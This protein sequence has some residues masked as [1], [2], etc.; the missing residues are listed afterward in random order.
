MKTAY[1][2][3]GQGSQSVGM[4]ADLYTR[5][6]EARAVLDDADRL[7]DFPLQERMFG[8]GDAEADRIALTQTDVT[9]P[10]LFAHSAAVAAVLA[11]RG[12]APEATAGHSLGEYSALY[13][14][15][16]IDFDDALRLVRLR[17]RLMARAE[18]ERPGAMSA[19]LNLDADVLERVCREA[20]EAGEGEVVPANFN[21]PGQI[22]ISGDAEAVAR[23]G[24]AAKA[25]GARR[26][27]PLPVGGAF[28]SPLMAYAVDEFAE[29]LDAVSLREPAVPVYL[30]VTAEPTTDAGLIRK[31]LLEQLTAPVRWAQ[32]LE[33]MRADGFGR[34]V[35]VGS[36][37]V[38]SGLVKRTL[39][40]EVET[41]T[42]GT[43]D[44][45][46]AVQP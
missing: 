36:G 35:E 38:L 5:F 6:P 42:V 27:V 1:L 41:V 25:V 4:A 31:K 34:F 9:Q 28:H 3:P 39:G 23:A 37:N 22:V 26:V 32:T 14:A 18:D 12:H 2:F 45:L 13:A 17:G 44:E 30:N 40:R 19:V 29:A 46:D 21:A 43:A 20:T 16:A 10:A 8:T 24:E 33:A 15:G 7:L 11:A